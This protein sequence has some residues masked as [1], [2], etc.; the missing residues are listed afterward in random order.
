MEV[1]Q[2]PKEYFHKHTLSFLF[3]TSTQIHRL[4]HH[5]LI[6]LRP[7]FLR[8]FLFFLYL[9]LVSFFFCLGF[10][11]ILPF[12]G[13]Q[14]SHAKT[15]FMGVFLKIFKEVGLLGGIISF[16][17]QSIDVLFLHLQE[18]LLGMGSNLG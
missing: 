10:H 16:T 18:H 15:I 9:G 8:I 7:V 3:F 12:G 1:G 5:S 14:M 4:I 17:E 6:F 2:I 11:L 13:S